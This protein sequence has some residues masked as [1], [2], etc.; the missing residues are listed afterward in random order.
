MASAA[1]KVA[2][3]TVDNTT[4][5]VP[6]R[7]VDSGASGKTVAAMIEEEAV[8]SIKKKVEDRV[9]EESIN[10]ADE[11]WKEDSIGEK[12]PKDDADADG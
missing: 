6:S 1:A 8:T 5:V 3:Q 7:A 11:F 9:V 2:K 4:K 12:A 10:K